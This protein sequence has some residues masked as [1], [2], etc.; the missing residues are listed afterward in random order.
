MKGLK[1]LSLIL[2]MYSVCVFGK[3]R[4]IAGYEPQSEVVQHARI[5][6]D[7]QDIINELPSAESGNVNDCSGTNCDWDTTYHD[8]VMA[9]WYI[10]QNGK[11][12]AKSNSN[13]TIA[14]FSSGAQTKSSGNSVSTDL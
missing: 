12:S 7:V 11:N 9:A 13:R 3:Y 6:L 8:E 1:Q 5:D 4:Y 2:S 14:G 10:W